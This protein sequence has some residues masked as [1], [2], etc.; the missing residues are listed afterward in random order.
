MPRGIEP[1]YDAASNELAMSACRPS[2]NFL[3]DR[4]RTSAVKSRYSSNNI[5][6]NPFPITCSG[7]D[8]GGV[9]FHVVRRFMI[10]Q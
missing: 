5:L 8:K 9:L 6:I 1:T 4:K 7:C 3:M 2:G 10:E